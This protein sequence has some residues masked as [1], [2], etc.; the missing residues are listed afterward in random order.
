MI[1]PQVEIIK[2]ENGDLLDESVIVSVMTC[3]AQC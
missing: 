2:D 3:A 1:T